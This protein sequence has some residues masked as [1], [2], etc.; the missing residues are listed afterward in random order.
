MHV[1]VGDFDA[2]LDAAHGVADLEAQVPERV[3]DAVN[4]FGEVGQG[5]AAGDDLPVLQEH[6][7]NVAVRVELGAAKAADGDE[8]QFRKLFLRLGRQT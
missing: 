3:K 5:F 7:V 8:R 4:E 1:A 6:E 2:I